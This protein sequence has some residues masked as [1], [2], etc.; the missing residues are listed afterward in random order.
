MIKG[1][2]FEGGGPAGIGHIG[3][4][5]IFEKNNLMQN[6]T[7]FG[8]SSAG[9]IMAAALACRASFKFLKKL[10][11]TTDFNQFK[12]RR[13]YFFQRIH[14]FFKD[15]GWYQT[16]KIDEW[17][18]DFLCKLTGDRD[19]TF[20]QVY[21]RFGTH[22]MVT[23]TDVNHGTLYI[24][25]YNSPD[26][27]VRTG[28]KRSAS[29]PFFFRSDREFKNGIKHLYTD[30]GI[31]NNYPIGVFDHILDPSEVVGFKLIS[32][33]EKIKNLNF[34]LNK[35]KYSMQ[36]KS[37]SKVSKSVES[38]PSNLVAYSQCLLTIMREQA[39][40]IHINHDD[41]KRTIKINIGEISAT[42]FNL[43][44]SDKDFLIEGGRNGAL[45]FLDFEK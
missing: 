8:G 36:N 13:D 5:E 34:D 11:Y 33:D 15:F 6:V 37:K 10:L 32:S 18:G 3:A 2:I 12:D 16:K 38:G 26:M 20:Q 40:Q 23:I 4:I 25:R 17:I 42:D 21:Q 35:R 27:K 7:H 24:D 31:L 41:W 28:V 45:K 22:L 1:M 39:L 30:G 29:L 14:G 19:I 44:D 9:A 43:T